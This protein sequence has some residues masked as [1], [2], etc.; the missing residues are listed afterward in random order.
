[1]LEIKEPPSYGTLRSLENSLN[2][3]LAKYA[4]ETETS[5]AMARRDSRHQLFTLCPSLPTWL[6]DKLVNP[7]RV[8]PYKE[9][10]MH[11]ILVSC[12]SIQFRLQAPIDGEKGPLGQVISTLLSSSLAYNFI[13]IL[14]RTCPAGGTIFDDNGFVRSETE[15][16]ID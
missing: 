12:Q 16:E 5:I 1:M 13:S 10:L 9:K 11:R 4:R 3:Q 14:S 15:Q 6:N 8:D 2:P 7:C